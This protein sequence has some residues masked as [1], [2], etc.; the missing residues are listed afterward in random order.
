MR[1]EKRTL[2]GALSLDRCPGCAA[3]GTEEAS[4]KKARNE[5]RNKK[6]PPKKPAGHC[7]ETV[8]PVCFPTAGAGSSHI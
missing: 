5:R 8:V 3:G 2:K 7:H 4:G 1:Q 6:S